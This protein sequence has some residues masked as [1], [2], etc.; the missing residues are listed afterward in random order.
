MGNIPPGQ[1]ATQLLQFVVLDE[2]G[3]PSVVADTRATVIWDSFINGTDIFIGRSLSLKIANWIADPAADDGSAYPL[4]ASLQTDAGNVS[5]FHNI[6]ATVDPNID[7]TQVQWVPGSLSVA[8]NSVGS[9]G[10][11]WQ[12]LQSST[13]L[14]NTN[15]TDVVTNL[16]WPSPQTNYWTNSSVSGNARFYRIVQP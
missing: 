11:T 3:S 10:I 15:W 8:L 2:F 5:V 4:D 9:S 12:I 13:N 6:I 7:I 14:M 16:V 1:S